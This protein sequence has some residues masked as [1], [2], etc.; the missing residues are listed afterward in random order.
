MSKISRRAFIAGVAVTVAGAGA[1]VYGLSGCATFTK[2][3]NTPAIP[4][5]A[6]LFANKEIRIDLRKVP[7][8]GKVGGSVKIIDSKIPQSIIVARS[9]D[10]DFVVASLKCPHRGVEVEYKHEEKQF[11]CASI[12]HS[13]FGTDGACKKGFA[14][15]PLVKFDAQLDPEDKNRLIITLPD[16][17]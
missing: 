8:L 15:H 17:H 13:T 3:G 11:R 5:D 12:G 6:Y 7:A 2:V 4:A 16:I 14:K 1:C 10:T 9:G